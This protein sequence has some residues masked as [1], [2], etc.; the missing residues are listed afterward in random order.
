MP[1]LRAVVVVDYQNVHL[2]A[3]E[4]FAVSRHLPRHESLVDPLHFANQLIIARNRAQRPGMDHAELAHVLVYRGQPSAE[5]DPKPYARNQAQKAHWERDG[6]VTVTHR[7]LKYRY[8]R[9]PAGRAV[10]GP[11]GKRVVE[12][13]GEKGIDVLCALAV[14]REAQR[15][16][17]DLVVLASHDSDLEPALDE[18]LVLDSAKIETFSWY[19]PA[20]PHR[21]RQLRPGSGRRIWNT[22]LG[23]IEFRNCWDLTKYP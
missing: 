8:Q 22:R 17:V 19:D 23:G 5:H 14:V 4:L 10:L 18:A 20:Q 12:S 15:S 13:K 9:D 1:D 6:R 2:T 16:D 7:P 21:I 3:H 11:D